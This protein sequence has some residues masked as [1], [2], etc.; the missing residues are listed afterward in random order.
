MATRQLS[1]GLSGNAASPRAEGG[2]DVASRFSALLPPG[3]D[4][5]ELPTYPSRPS[6]KGLTSSLSLRT[7]CVVSDGARGG[8]DRFA[9]ASVPIYATATFVQPSASEFGPFDYS[10]SGNPTRTALERQAAMLEGAHA[11]FA[12]T[13]GMAA[14]STLT[15]LLRTG[16]ELLVGSDIYGGMHRLVSR[17]A[18]ALHGVRVRFVDTSAGPAAVEA[19][20]SP[21]TRMVHIETP[22]NPLMRITDVRALAALLRPRGVLFSV[23]STMMP[24]VLSRPLA[25]GADLVVHSA[26]KFWG[27]HSDVMG[28]LLCANDP[29]LCQRIAF[30]QNA[31][32]TGLDPFSCW[33][34]L[35]GIKTMALRVERAQD[36][37]RAVAAYLAGHTA[38]T[39]VYFPGAL[40]AGAA[41]TAASVDATQQAALHASQAAGPGVV[42]SFTTGSVELSRRIIDSLRIFK[43]TVSFGSVTSLC[44]MP[45]TGSH[46]SIPAELR[47]I[48]EDLIRL[49]VGIEDID[50]LLH[51]LHQAFE[52][53]THPHVPNVRSVRRRD[54]EDDGAFAL[55]TTSASGEAAAEA[56]LTALRSSVAQLA[57]A[58]DAQRAAAEAARTRAGAYALVAGAAIAAV[59]AAV[60]VAQTRRRQ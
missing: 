58:L 35:R 51:D 7:L 20:L 40:P 15:R 11:A 42:M 1:L 59:A 39:H 45:C 13:S 50:D 14:L 27:G 2:D 41:N 44:E 52:L 24:P 32:G 3:A 43:L 6:Y 8:G 31:E 12:F 57:A 17:V 46:A 34:F 38:V 30:F 55:T 26:T 23:D 18:T 19:A 37:A 16:D 56:E 60:W 28:G 47:K 36:N 5:N 48:P 21:T 29:A 54:T 22:S 49:S 25:L 4:Y 10:R 33:L 53:A 9:P